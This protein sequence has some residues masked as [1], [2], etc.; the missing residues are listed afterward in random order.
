MCAHEEGYVHTACVYTRRDTCIHAE[1]LKESILPLPLP[2]FPL[3]GLSLQLKLMVF[4][5]CRTSPRLDV[6]AAIQILVF[7]FEQLMLFITETSL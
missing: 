5:I 7:I 3:Q 2:F 4:G 1:R 6:G